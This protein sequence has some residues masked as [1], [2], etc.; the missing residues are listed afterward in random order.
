MTKRQ[1]DIERYLRG[2][3]S[4]AEMHALEKEA[5]S[6]PF[7]ADALEG[8]QNTG[9]ENFLFDL[10]DLHHSVSNRSVKHKPKIISMWNWSIGI[11][12]TLLL[13]AVSGIYIVGKIS[14][15]R[16]L[17]AENANEVEDIP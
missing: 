3:M 7:L 1:N 9:T 11:A 13:I 15:E 8:A 5:L 17:L 14:S 2:E 16:A 4:A 10:A 6:D 12:A